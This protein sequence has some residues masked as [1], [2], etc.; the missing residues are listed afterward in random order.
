MSNAAPDDDKGRLT[1]LKRVPSLNSLRAFDSVARHGSCT[2]AAAELNVTAAAV[3]QQIRLLEEFAG[4][5]LF[6][7][8]NRQLILNQAGAACLPE[9]RKSFEHL[10]NAMGQLNTTGGR[11]RFNLSVPPSFAVRWLIPNLNEVIKSAEGYDIWVSTSLVPFHLADTN[12]DVAVIHGTGDFFGQEAELLIPAVEVPVCSPLLLR[13]KPIHTPQDL[14]NHLLIHEV[15]EV[16]DP[17]VPS[18]ENWLK[19]RGITNVDYD[20]GPRF[21][22]PNLVIEAAIAGIGVALSRGALVSRDIESG[23]LCQLFGTPER[24]NT[25]YYIVPNSRSEHSAFASQLADILKRIVQKQVQTRP[26]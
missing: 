6:R 7:R 8:H 13:D 24:G 1:L 26:V 23:K 20:S 25:G 14:S 9:L 16:N 21:S 4:R 5:E 18:W 3:S 22:N 15:A 11:K 2:K 17:A 10:I 19:H 12:I